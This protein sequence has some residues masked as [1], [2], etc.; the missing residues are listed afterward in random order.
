[1]IVEQFLFTYKVQTGVMSGISTS[2][3]LLLAY[4]LGQLYI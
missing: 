3:F 2:S 1:M 4:L